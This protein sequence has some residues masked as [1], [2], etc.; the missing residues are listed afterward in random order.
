M[1]I[2]EAD[3]EHAE[4]VLT[5][6]CDRVPPD[7]RDKLRYEFELAGNTYT[8]VE[9]RPYLTAPTRGYMRLGL[10]R[11]KY[12]PTKR[13]W[14]LMWS[15]RNERWHTYKGFEYVD[16]IDELIAEIQRDPTHIFFG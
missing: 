13:A 1:P 11:L 12:R 2:P 5:T 14:T 6:F 10:A 9:I 3:R 16:T 15:D 4:K 7:I 8:I